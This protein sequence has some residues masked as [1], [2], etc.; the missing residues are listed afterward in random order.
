MNPLKVLQ[1]L[2][3]EISETLF[4]F[5]ET[6]I[7]IYDFIRPETVELFD[8]QKIPFPDNLREFVKSYN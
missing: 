4:F 6:D 5:V 1:D 7:K 8:I 2:K 3:H